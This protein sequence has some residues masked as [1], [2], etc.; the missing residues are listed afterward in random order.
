MRC[1]TAV[2][3]LPDLL[4][5]LAETL[6]SL[7]DM[8]GRSAKRSDHSGRGSS[9]GSGGSTTPLAKKLGIVDGAPVVT[10]DAPPGWAIPALPGGVRTLRRTRRV[11][12]LRRAC[13]GDRRLRAQRGAPREG[14][15][16]TRR[17]HVRDRVPLD[18][19]APPA[20]AATTAT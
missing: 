11:A 12:N 4:R 5:I 19:L 10:V 6:D 3:L 20:R 8:G 9:P 15:T 18:R 1:F 14:G 16:R 13:G 17:R 2:V 7:S